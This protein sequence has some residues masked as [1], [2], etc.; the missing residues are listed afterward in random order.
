MA[1]TFSSPSTPT[2]RGF[3]SFAHTPTKSSPLAYPADSSPVLSPTSVAQERRRSQYKAAALSTPF[4]NQIGSSSR[5]ESTNSAPPPRL[6]LPGLAEEAP[7]KRFLRERFRARCLERAL[8]DRERKI[9]GKRR[10]SDWSSDGPEEMMDYDDDDDEED[11]DESM[12]NDAV[13][14]VGANVSVRHRHSLV[15]FAHHSECKA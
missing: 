12:L 9:S 5:R 2:H 7:G 1:T 8:K 3:A 6:E 13:R 11:E 4:A 14:A 10:A 15:L